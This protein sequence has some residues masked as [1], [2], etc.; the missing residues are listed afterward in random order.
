MQRNP[1]R[2]NL[3]SL[4]RRTAPQPILPV[5]RIT[6]DQ[7]SRFRPVG[8]RTIQ[9]K[10]IQRNI[11]RE[12]G[13]YIKTSAR[14]GWQKHAEEAMVAEYNER[15]SQTLTQISYDSIKLARCH[16]GSYDGIQEQIVQYLNGAQSES[17]FDSFVNQF[18]SVLSHSSDEYVRI[19]VALSGLKKTIAGSSLDDVVADANKLLSLLNNLSENLRA[20]DKYLNSFLGERTDLMFTIDAFGKYSL[21]EHSRRILAM[22][23]SFFGKLPLTPQKGSR[24]ITSQGPVAIGDMSP[25]STSLV[26]AYPS[27]RA[28][29]KSK[30]VESRI[31]G[32]GVVKSFRSAP[33]QKINLTL[34]AP[35]MTQPTLTST[36]P[37]L[38]AP[39]QPTFSFQP[40]QPTVL[41]PLPPPPSYTLHSFVY[42]FRDGSAVFNAT[43]SL[44]G[45]PTYVKVLPNMTRVNLGHDWKAP[46]RYE[47][48]QPVYYFSDGA[49]AYNAWDGHFRKD[50]YLKVTTS[51]YQD[52][53]SS[54]TVPSRYMSEKLI[55]SHPD[56]TA[57]YYAWDGEQRTYTC[58]HVTG[59]K[60]LRDL[61]LSW[62][63]PP[64][65]PQPAPQYQAWQYSSSQYPGSKPF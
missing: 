31:Y 60:V 40:P 48:L 25:R 3:A 38:S 51:A 55:A 30:K 8:Q 32:G 34:S 23:P 50:T 61:G 5:R 22:D 63:T 39:P 62:L 7:I 64:Q 58:I 35:A 57:V 42:A 6:R 24:V 59:T 56:G 45:A 46:A 1:S 14:A 20:A 10:V 33:K 12:G 37:I 11:S 4:Q 54:W 53:G 43:A 18:I 17:A 49:T 65:P 27:Q 52:L 13:K 26:T 41:F 21:S 19:V 29:I 36:P 2:P 28:P 15:T 16:V 44:S 47:L 9:A